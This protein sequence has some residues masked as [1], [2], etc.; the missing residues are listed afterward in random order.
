M[1]A[2]SYEE[3]PNGFCP[4][5]D[6]LSRL[7]NRAIEVF[8]LNQSNYPITLYRLERTVPSTEFGR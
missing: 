5:Q 4:V 7:G 8:N 6:A 1:C 3:C 2:S